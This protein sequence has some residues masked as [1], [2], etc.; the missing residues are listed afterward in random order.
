MYLSIDRIRLNIECVHLDT[1]AMQIES[2]LLRIVNHDGRVCGI[3]VTC[4][5]FIVDMI[6]EEGVLIERVH[7]YHIA[8]ALIGVGLVVGIEAVCGDGLRSIIDSRA[9]IELRT[10]SG[11]VVISILC[12][13]D[14]ILGCDYRRSYYV[15]KGGFRVVIHGVGSHCKLLILQFYVVIEHR[16]ACFRI[17]LSPVRSQCTAVI[18]EFSALKEIGNAI[19]TVVIQGVTIER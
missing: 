7:I 5:L 1:I 12:V 15:G 3:A 14:T 9:T 16:L 19:H 6:A 8:K 2:I 17:V 13:D 18:H 10:L 11:S 4:L